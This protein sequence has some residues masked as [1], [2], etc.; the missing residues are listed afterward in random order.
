MTMFHGIATK[1]GTRCP[2]S[3]RE[4]NSFAD[5][6]RCGTCGRVLRG[7]RVN[8]RGPYNENTRYVTPEHTVPTRLVER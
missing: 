5:R 4:W 8:R 1:P 3:G 2:E 6:D 7:K